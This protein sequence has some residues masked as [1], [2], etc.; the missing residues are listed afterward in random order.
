MLVALVLIGCASD[1]CS[2]ANADT[3]ALLAECKLRVERECPDL[4]RGECPV[5]EP[6]PQCPAIEQCDAKTREVC[7]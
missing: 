3:A 1:P 4:K 5:G 2:P 6:C 7:R